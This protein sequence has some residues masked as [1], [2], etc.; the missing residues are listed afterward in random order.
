LVY[1]GLTKLLWP[2]SGPTVLADLIGSSAWA[3]RT[4]ALGE[5]CTAAALLWRRPRPWLL[6]A[7]ILFLTFATP[8][9]LRELFWRSHPRPCGCGGFKLQ[10][11]E[12][13]LHAL[14]LSLSFAL[15]R[16]LLL[17]AAAS[18]LLRRLTKTP[19]TTAT[20]PG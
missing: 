10:A 8:L 14:K 5:L 15:A 20:N 9:I 11:W 12:D 4:L 13:S 6:A 1:S 7:L 2:S 18:W 16:N 3:H 17:F 19:T